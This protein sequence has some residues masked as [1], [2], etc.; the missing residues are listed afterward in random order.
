[1]ANQIRTKMRHFPL[2]ILLLLMLSCSNTKEY[3]E[4]YVYHENK[5]LKDVRIFELGTSSL[6]VVT[7]DTGHFKLKRQTSSNLI[8]SKIDFKTDTLELM[9]LH[10][11]SVFFL[12]E[13]AD[14][15]F[16]EP[17]GASLHQNTND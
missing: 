8:F 11:I 16:M 4:G 15:L 17:K 3:Y 6:S 2:V 13:Q 10:P 7:D 9:R 5:P 12:R 1:M 14:T